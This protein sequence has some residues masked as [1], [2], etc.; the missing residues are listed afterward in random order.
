MQQLMQKYT[1][2]IRRRNF[3]NII[4]QCKYI[5]NNLCTPNKDSDYISITIC[6]TSI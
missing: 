4:V 6:V 1:D 3:H 5:L 2:I